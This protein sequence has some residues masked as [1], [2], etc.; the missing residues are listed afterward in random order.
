MPNNRN[1]ILARADGLPIG[2]LFNKF[3][4]KTNRFDELDNETLDADKI[5]PNPKGIQ[6]TMKSST[7]EWIHKWKRETNNKKLKYEYDKCF[8]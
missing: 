7:V 3:L 6:K 5:I 1:N 8:Y 4:K 2:N